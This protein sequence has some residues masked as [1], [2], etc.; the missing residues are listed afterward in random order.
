MT[1]TTL[2]CI[3]N[4]VSI[5]CLF[6]ISTSS[7]DFCSNTLSNLL[8]CSPTCVSNE[9]E[10]ERKYVATDYGAFEPIQEL[11]LSRIDKDE[12]LNCRACMRRSF[13]YS[14]VHIC[15]F[16]PVNTKLLWCT[17]NQV[18][19]LCRSVIWPLQF[20]E[21]RDRIVP[22]V[23]TNPSAWRTSKTERNGVPTDASMYRSASRLVIRTIVESMPT[24]L[25]VTSLTYRINSATAD[26]AQPFQATIKGT[27]IGPSFSLFIDL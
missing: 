18:L 17:E 15:S 27:R 23:S 16:V 21:G 20:P 5:R 6:F 24:I 1:V 26:N 11:L 9:I 14:S 19:S 8:H 25:S 22:P 7:S 3:Y 12:S 4:H 13:N 10:R 2:V